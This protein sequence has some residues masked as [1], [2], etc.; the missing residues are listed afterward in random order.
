MTADLLASTASVFLSLLFSYV[1]GFKSWYE[2]QAP[3]S[4]RLIMLGLLALVAAGSFAAA[5]AQFGDALRLDVVCSRDGAIGLLEAFIAALV[6]NQ[7]AFL[8]SPKPNAGSKSRTV[9]RSEPESSAADDRA[10]P[11][12]NGEEKKAPVVKN[13]R[14]RRFTYFP[15]APDRRSDR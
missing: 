9:T 1:P 7:A 6:A 15:E 12:A 4:K 11:A 3:T 13:P 8:I 14:A 2:A 5:C 10:V